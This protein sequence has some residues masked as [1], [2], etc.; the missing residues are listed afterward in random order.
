M[1]RL[2]INLSRLKKS[3][4]QELE[5]HFLNTICNL[6]IKL[7]LIVFLILQIGTNSSAR[8]STRHRTKRISLLSNLLLC[9]QAN[10]ILGMSQYNYD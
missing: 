10:F 4:F 9:P 6:K 7:S 3:E 5:G 8:I 1:I 2:I